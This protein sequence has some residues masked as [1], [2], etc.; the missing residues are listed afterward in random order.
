MVAQHDRAGRLVDAQGFEGLAFPKARF[1]RA[2]L[3]ELFST[4]SRSVRLEGDQVVISRLYTER[5]VKPLDVYLEEAD[6]ETMR[7]AALDYGQTVR[8]LA[9]TGV[10]PGDLLLKNFG[11]T[12]H[13]RVVFYDYDELLPLS[14]CRFRELPEPRTPEEEMADEP[15]FAVGPGD[16]FPEELRRFIPFGG[17]ARQALLDAHGCLFDPA[18][19]RE[20]QARLAA[21]EIVEVFPYDA[22]RRLHPGRDEPGGAGGLPIP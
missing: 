2:L 16:V 21:G 4:A 14:E 10:F 19:W 13:G 6:E 3:T 15:W 1:T 5:R 7:H 20:M 12:R 17:A 8:D 18:Y 11:V 22:E 9:A